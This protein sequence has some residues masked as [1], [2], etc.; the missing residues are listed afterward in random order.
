M[1]DVDTKPDAEAPAGQ[2]PTTPTKSEPTEPETKPEPTALS[3]EDWQKEAEKAR[4]EAAKY[5]TKLREKEEAEAKAAE[6]KRKAELTAEERAKEAE[7]KA[8]EAVRAA[9]T[10]ALAAERRASLAGKVTN[11]DRV[12]RLMDDP[13]E[14]FGEGGEVNTDALAAAFP[15]YMPSTDG[16][17]RTAT[18]GAAGPAPKPITTREQIGKLTPAEYEAKRAEILAGMKR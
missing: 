4:K 16:S 7:R 2:E 10:R 13:T 11:P 12:L 8:E 6:D 9:E 15:E 17:K 1:P 3:Q 18:S 14:F 5:R